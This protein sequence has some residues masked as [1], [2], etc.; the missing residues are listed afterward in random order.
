M[1][2]NN[3]KSFILFIS[4]VLLIQLVNAQS[5]EIWEIQ[6]DSTVSPF[7]GQVIQ[8]ETNIVTV[9]D[10]DGF[11]LQTPSDRSDNN[12]E[13]SDGIKVVTNTRPSFAVGSV[14]NIAG[15]VK[16]VNGMT[17]I[18]GPNLTITD[19]ELIQDLPN[20]IQFDTDFPGTAA[21]LSPDLEQ[22]EGMLVQF[23]ALVTSPSNFDNEVTLTTQNQRPFREPGIDFPGITGLPVWDGNPEVFWF[24]PDKFG[25]P[26]NAFIGAGMRIQCNQAVLVQTDERYYAWPLN[27]QVIGNQLQRGVRS[28]AA[29]EITIAS[30]NML[31]FQFSESIYQTRIDKFAQYIAEL[32]NGP[33]IIAVQEVGGERELDDLVQLISRN[34]PLDYDVYFATANDGIHLAFLVKDNIDNVKIEQFFVETVFRT[35]KLHDRP[36]LLLSATI[37]TDPPTGINV[38][39]LH[40]RSRRD[41]EDSDRTDFVREKRF[42]QSKSVATLVQ[43]LQDQNL[44]VVGDFNA[45]EFTD[46]Y[47]DVVNQ[48]TGAATLGAAFT[49]E[50]IVSPP[51]IN[52]TAILPQEERYSFIFE[53]NAQLLD[54]C[55]INNLADFT[56]NDLQF[57]RGN[58]DSPRN[59]IVN[60]NTPLR[61]TD[62]D[63]FVLFLNPEG[64]IISNSEQLEYSSTIDVNYLNPTSSGGLVSIKN[65]KRLDIHIQILANNGQIIKSKV[66]GNQE[67]TEFTLPNHLVAGQ[68]WITVY[69]EGEKV[70]TYS[71]TV[72]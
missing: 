14:L 17:V 47:V 68:Y 28:K 72:R 48:I 23:D 69:A 64:M 43:D 49:P 13:T 21:K 70:K 29:E 71:V 38:L 44:V 52:Q 51:L 56:I 42:E 20:T 54:H 65:P 60:A 7:V 4:S 37:P 53:G 30:I 46:G 2:I 62:H 34:Y 66:I 26:N 35:G 27:Y 61:S 63:A 45:F 24:D 57:A 40:L 19:Q 5:L 25:G 16:E 32:L 36:P 12:S 11:Y 41:I 9:L 10:S 58:A 31:Q 22:V 50:V 59:L 67:F 39:N 33:D 15:T 1:Y 55:L 8:T 18:T 6:G 3:G